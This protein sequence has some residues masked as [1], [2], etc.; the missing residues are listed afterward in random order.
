M[1]MIVAPMIVIVAVVAIRVI[2][3]IHGDM[4]AYDVCGGR[5]QRFR[6]LAVARQRLALCLRTMT[7]LYLGIDEAI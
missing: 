6:V 5:Q 3:N 2:A 4:H 1:V 7:N